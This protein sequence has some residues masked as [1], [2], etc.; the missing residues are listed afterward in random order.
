[1]I[2]RSLVLLALAVLLAAGGGLP[3]RAGTRTT[4]TL[5]T[6][7]S[8]NVSRGVL[9]A[10]TRSTDIE[11]EILRAGDAG[12]AL[13]QVI[14]TKDNPLGDVLYGV[15][16]TFLSRALK[17]EIF[18]PYESPDLS[19]VPSRYVL[20][21]RHRV[22]P[23]D[24]SYVCIN[25]DRQW[26]DEAGL[27]PPDSFEDLTDPM[28]EGLLVVEHPATSSPGLS[29]LLATRAAFEGDRWASWWQELREN[30]VAVVEGWEQAWYERFTAASESGDRP[31][32]VSYGSSPPA[33]VPEGGGPARAGTVISTCIEQIE[34]V[35]VLAGTEH[36]RAARRVVDFMLSK[37]FQEDVPEQMYVF[38]V[39]D[40]AELPELFVRYAEVPEDP[41]LEIP[42]GKIERNREKWIREWTDIVLR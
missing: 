13:N 20:D 25:Y 32:V 16:N 19:T 10:F 40:D 33:T 26:F 1:M 37:E 3:A 29:F 31:L 24:R 4:V 23:V 8:F 2:R 7:D 5:V 41:T 11:I 21:G 17:E 9:R 39:R 15:D 27:T 12:Q 22:T 6:H 35:G 30:D 36:R 34:F 18:E 14:L 38:P 28:Y 42:P